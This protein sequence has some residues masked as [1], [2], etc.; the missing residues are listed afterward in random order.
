MANRNL[1]HGRSAVA[2]RPLSILVVPTPSMMAGDDHF[3]GGETQVLE[4]VQ[5]LRTRGHDVT[6]DRDLSVLMSASAERMDVVHVFS[7]AHADEVRWQIVERLHSLKG[8]V[9]TCL[10]PIYWN[11]TVSEIAC[12]VPLTVWKMEDATDRERY[13]QLMREPGFLVNG[14]G[15]HQMVLRH[16]LFGYEDAVRLVLPNGTTEAHLVAR[17]LKDPTVLVIPVVNGMRVDRLQQ[18]AESRPKDIVMVAAARLEPRKNQLMAVL[19]LRE[20]PLPLVLIGDPGDHRDYLKA[21]QEAATPYVVVIPRRLP[22]DEYVPLLART[23]VH[24]LP[25]WNETTGIASLEAAWMGASLVLGNR[26]GER[27]YFREYARYVD[28]TDWRRIR[29]AVYDAWERYDDE[30]EDRHAL[31]E[32]IAT[33]YTWEKAAEQTERAYRLAMRRLG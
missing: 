29:Q 26:G 33:T 30:D 7:I 11:D 5:A 24:L 17:T 28:P 31:R 13:L 6:L 22:P 21:I 19:A 8:R 1:A 18:L 12:Q 27:D 10:S 14:T 25:S 9:V 32:L 20:G 15:I 3:G 23:R 2:A 16:H 4:T